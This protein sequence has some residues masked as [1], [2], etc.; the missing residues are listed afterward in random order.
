MTMTTENTN[1]NESY[2]APSLADSELSDEE[3]N[4][5]AGGQTVFTP[6]TTKKNIFTPQTTKKNKFKL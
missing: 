2:Q 6:Q 1:E 5:V 3:L 4:A